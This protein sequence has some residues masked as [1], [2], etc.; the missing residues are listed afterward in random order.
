MSI[1][2]DGRRRTRRFKDQEVLP[3]LREAFS[4]RP[5][6]LR[7]S[8]HQLSILMFFYSYT[9][10]PLEEFDI[11]VALPFALEDWEGAA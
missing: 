1:A 8:P 2:D 6:W 7:F 11:G 4:N 10:Q 5:E 3:A 9:P